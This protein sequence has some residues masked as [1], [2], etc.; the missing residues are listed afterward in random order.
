MFFNRR[1]FSHI[2]QKLKMN[3][4]FI[5]FL[6]VCSCHFVS[7][8]YFTK[9]IDGPLVNTIGDSRSVNWIDVNK[10]GWI[11]C[12]ISN[13]PTGGQNNFLYLNDK[14]GNFTAVLADPLTL[15]NKPSDGASFG[16][17]DND[18]DIDA[19]VVNW[20]NVNNLF[21]LNNGQGQ[22][23]QIDTG[24][25]VT[26]AGYSE[27]ASWGDYDQ[28][29]LLDL[30]VTNSAGTYK[31]YMYHN[32]G[33]GFSKVATGLPVMDAYASR[34]VNWTDVDGDGDLDL[35]VTNENNQNE[36]LYINAGGIFTSAANSDLVNNHGNTMSASWADYDND[37]D[38]D[39][40]LANDQGKNALFQNNGQLSFTKIINDT[41]VQ[42]AA[43]SFSAA[44]SD[45]DNDG[46]LDLFVTN[47]FGTAYKL[48]NYF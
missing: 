21:Y 7:A 32:N 28:D 4:L 47:S 33:S 30:Y 9:V 2:A 1:I 20:Y 14:H 38:M 34:C 6:L 3:K 43:R 31:N 17:V 18:G 10:D 13:G 25:L 40:F 35:F 22:F 42:T 39:V 11:D 44:W 46:D 16:D 41:I 8:Q 24:K 5:F 23:N 36:N 26:D 29:G 45:V 15:D 12:F 19:F 27:T 37:G 48:L